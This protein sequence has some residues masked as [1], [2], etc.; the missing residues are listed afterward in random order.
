MNS[1]AVSTGGLAWDINEVFDGIISLAD[2]IN[3]SIAER[4]R[5]EYPP[6]P[7]PPD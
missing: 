1:I 5:V 7:P 3:P 6:P 2:P 4:H